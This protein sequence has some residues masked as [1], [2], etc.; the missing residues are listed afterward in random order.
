M[1]FWLKHCSGFLEPKLIENPPTHTKVRGHGCGARQTTG[2][3]PS[4]NQGRRGEVAE[5]T[6]GHLGGQG[7]P[8]SHPSG[9]GRIGLRHGG[10]PGGSLEHPGCGQ[11]KWSPGPG[12]P[13][14]REWIQ[15]PDLGL[16]GNAPPSGSTGGSKLGQGGQPGRPPG[17]P[18][19]PDKGSLSVTGA[20]WKM[21]TWPGMG[22]RSRGWNSRV[23]MATSRSNGA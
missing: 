23:V 1:P 22:P 8:L 10:R 7:H 2:G 15:R 19:G 5:A 11:G 3:G 9:T 6:G 4:R 21:L 17:G 20:S 14:W 12:S 13:G 18:C 16:H